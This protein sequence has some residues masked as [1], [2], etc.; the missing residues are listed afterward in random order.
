MTESRI[1]VVSALASAAFAL[2]GLVLGIISHSGMILFDA[3]YSTITIV[4]TLL[5]I[6]IIKLAEAK[7]SAR[8]PYG[9]ALFE[10]MFVFF[11]SLALIGMC[12]FTASAAITDL[13]SG[14]RY[15][16]PSLGLIYASICSLGCFSM[17]WL[18]KRC[19]R[20]LQSLLISL[21]GKLW[22]GDAYLSTAVLLGFALS[23]LLQLSAWPQWVVYADPIMVLIASAAFI[24]IPT[25]LAYRSIKEVLLHRADPDTVDSI[26][27][28]LLQSLQ[29]QHIEVD[30]YRL[31]VVR[32][33]RELSVEANL[34]I[35]QGRYFDAATADRIRAD[36]LTTAKQHAAQQF[37]NV[38]ATAERQWL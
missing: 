22:L 21:E 4:L 15:V 2:Y 13:L 24:M 29:G 5:S 9:K 36:L 1:L 3:V 18:I 34:L 26:R 38:S 14:G 6:Y 28:A 17:A 35:A 10:P 30:D 27:Q 20:N 19:N 31:K 25:R 8:F 11:Q 12:V 7:Q 33:G 32:T 16:A 23:F 37:I